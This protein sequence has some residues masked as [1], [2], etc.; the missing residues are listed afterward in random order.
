MASRSEFN[1]FHGK[2]AYAITTIGVTV[3]SRAYM[4]V[5]HYNRPVQ[6]FPRLTK[7]IKY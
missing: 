3:L 4:T 7:Q 5:S 1:A 2:L 6:I